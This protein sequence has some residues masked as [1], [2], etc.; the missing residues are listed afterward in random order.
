MLFLDLAYEK[1]EFKNQRN[2]KAVQLQ[3][4]NFNFIHKMKPLTQ[5]VSMA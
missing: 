4:S 3:N 1:M 5:I 2:S